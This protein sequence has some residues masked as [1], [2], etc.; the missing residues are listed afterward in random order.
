LSSTWARTTV[1][2]PREARRKQNTATSLFMS[3]SFQDRVR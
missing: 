2:V 3:A 1:A